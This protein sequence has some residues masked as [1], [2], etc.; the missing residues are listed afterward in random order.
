MEEAHINPN[1]TDDETTTLPEGIAGPIHE[2][3]SNLFNSQWEYEEKFPRISTARKASTVEEED[4][5]S[6][7]PFESFQDRVIQV[8]EK[9]DYKYIGEIKNEIREG[10]GVCYYKNGSVYKGMWINDR[11]EGL[12][13]FI[14]SSGEITQGEINDD[15]FNGYVEFSHPNKKFSIS[16]DYRHNHFTDYVIVKSRHKVFEGE[17]CDK[18]SKI[19]IGKLISNKNENFKIF[20]GEISNYT[21]E[22][23]YGILFNNNSMYLGEIRNKLFENYIELYNKDGAAYFGSIE[24]NLKQGICFTFSKDGKVTFGKYTDNFRNGPFLSFSNCH[25]L[26]KSSVRLEIFHLDFK[27]KVV[28]KMEPSKKYLLTNYP[29]YCYI[30]NINYNDLIYKLNEVLLEEMTFFNTISNS[31]PLPK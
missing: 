4:R 13:I 16:G 7:E 23:G 18:E 9:E 8:I 31:L 17:V 10:F 3:L 21:Q 15:C 6:R 12:G 19:S 27:S 29:E 5:W 1:F 22:C 20:M 24:K 25:N 30:L 26:A 2:N 14:N 11:R 28:D